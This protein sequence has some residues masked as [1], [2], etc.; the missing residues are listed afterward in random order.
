MTVDRNQIIAEELSKREPFVWGARDC[1]LWSASVVERV[2]G[3][4]FAQVYRGT[5]STQHGALRAIQKAGGLVE[6]I[7]SVLGDP[8]QPIKAARGDP[9]LGFAPDPSAGICVGHRAAFIRQDGT[10]LMLDLDRCTA[11]WS[12]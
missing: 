3:K 10:F 8:I 2:T 5:Y 12:V 6:L 9:V 4:D 7:S 1:C 11:A